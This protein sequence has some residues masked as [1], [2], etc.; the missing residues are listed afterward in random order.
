MGE[1]RWWCGLSVADAAVLELFLKV[2]EVEPD[3]VH[4]HVPVGGCPDLTVVGGDAAMVKMAQWSYPRRVDFVLRFG[5]E[6]WL[7]ECKPRGR[8]HA[9]GQLLA[10]FYWWCRDVPECPVSRL[11]MVTETCDAD[12]VEFAGHLGIDVVECACLGKSTE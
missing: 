9:V 1:L 12:V 8:V 3:E 6:W 11:V 5:R 2:L 4:T 7:C 10:Y